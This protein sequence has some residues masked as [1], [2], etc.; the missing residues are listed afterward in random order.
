MLL[1]Y[2]FMDIVDKVSP[3]FCMSNFGGIK[4]SQ[5]CKLWAAFCVI[6]STVAVE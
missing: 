5:L 3:V 6:G 4:L 2:I 1:V